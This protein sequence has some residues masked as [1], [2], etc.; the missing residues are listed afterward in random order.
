[1]G[2][3]DF[4]M[5]TFEKSAK[6]FERKYKQYAALENSA[7]DPLANFRAGANLKYGNDSYA[8]M[9]ECAKDYARKHIAYIESHGITG[10]SV[11]ESLGDIMVYA[12]IMRYLKARNVACEPKRVEEGQ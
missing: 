3:K 1:M 2:Y 7:Y 10:K 12:A 8:A 5:K 4:V 11:D 6:L 9:Y